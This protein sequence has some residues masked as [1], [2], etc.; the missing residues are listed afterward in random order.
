[1]LTQEVLEFKVLPAVGQ[2]MVDRGMELSEE[3]IQPANIP[4]RFD[5]LG[6]NVRRQEE[7]N[8]R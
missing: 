6:Q 5:F 1:M 8:E 2:F 7:S 3:M 4:D